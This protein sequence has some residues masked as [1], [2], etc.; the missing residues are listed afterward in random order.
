MLRVEQVSKS[1]GSG[2]VLSSVSFEAHPGRVS[3]IVGRN[4]CGK[5]TLLAIVSGMLRPDSGRVLLADK[6]LLQNP[7]LRAC[8]GYLAQGDSLFEELS[9]S[10][11][12]LFWASAAG[13]SSG[14]LSSN[15]FVRLLGLEEFWGKRISRLSGGMRR[16]VAICAALLSDPDYILLDEPFAGLDILYRQE[17]VDFLLTLRKMGKAIIYTTHSAQELAALG[18][19]ALLL[20]EGEVAVRD[21]IHALSAA[22][23][24]LQERLTSYLKGE[25][26]L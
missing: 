1:Y 16:R 13:H 12:I 24:N 14:Q 26:D 6:D 22:G 25:E 18:D 23:I 15:R 17:L 2:Q 11:N 21:D 19:V 4:G 7:G 20:R 10:E 9:V 3:A 5:S 8:I